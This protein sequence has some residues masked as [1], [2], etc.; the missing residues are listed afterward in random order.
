[1]SYFDTRKTAP[2]F[3]PAFFGGFGLFPPVIKALLISNVVVWFL[4]DVLLPPF[5]FQGIPI[6]LI[7]GNL[8]ALHPLGGDFWP[9]QLL[10]YMFLHGGFLHLFFN[11]LAL[12]MFGMELEQ[13]WG[14]RK[15]LFYYLACGVGGGLVNL[16]VAPLVGQAGPTV[17]AS[18]AVFGVLLAF[19]VMFPDRPIYLYFLLPVRAKYFIAG[20]IALELVYGVTGTSQGVAHFAHLGGAAVGLVYLLVSRDMVPTRPR[21]WSFGRRARFPSM[22]EQRM[23]RVDEHGEVHDATFYDVHTGRPTTPGGQRI[24]QEMVDAI[25]D[26]INRSGYQSLAEEEKRILHEASKNM[27]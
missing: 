26:K 18:G 21:W 20:Y 24:T 14:S 8:L 1:M 19:G 17:G 22:N 12:W 4:L 2:S 25:L 9:W 13:T 16:L 11:M 5:T 10:T 3:R 7:L 15:F 6:F 27:N 23:F